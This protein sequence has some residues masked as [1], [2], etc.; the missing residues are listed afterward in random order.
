MWRYDK[1]VYTR[2]L[3]YAI[4]VIDAV[5]EV[6]RRFLAI[7]SPLW[8]Q[9]FPVLVP[10]RILLLRTEYIGDLVL[11]TPAFK[12]VRESFPHAHIA[13]LVQ[14]RTAPL[15]KFNPDVNEV[16]SCTLPWYEREK[17]PARIANP[18]KRAVATIQYH[19]HCIKTVFWL[20][21]QLR[22]RRFDVAIDL[23]RHIYTLILMAA[24]GIPV[25]I[26]DPRAGG[27]FLLTHP[28]TPD[29]KKHEVE[30][31]LDIVSVLGVNT[32]KPCLTLNW[33]P[34]DEEHVIK[35]WTHLGLDENRPVI[36]IHPFSVEPSRCWR[37]E[38]WAI[39]ADALVDLFGARILFIGSTTDQMAVSDIQQKM[40]NQSIN[41]CGEL[42]LLQLAALLKRCDLMIGVNSGPAH[43]AAAVGIPVVSIWSSAYLPEKW[44]PYTPKLRLVRKQVPCADCR[45]I[46]CPL[47]VSCMDMITP[48]EVIAAVEEMLRE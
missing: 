17:H 36:A 41:L 19:W 38:N 7:F 5:G 46:K 21:H 23:G 16:I 47:P 18:F 6:V 12:A 39:V 26:G 43:I 32:Q 48:E 40:R 25:R 20:A 3:I 31:C 42:S 37:P 2:R 27:K 9:Q 24:A 15:L 34:A 30:R 28:V 45:L 29:D 1:L 10:K 14:S 13:V 8:R 44:A 35:L 22:E 4:I 11:A 33:S